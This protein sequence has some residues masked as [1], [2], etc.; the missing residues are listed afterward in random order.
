MESAARNDPPYVRI[1]AE[2]SASIRSGELQPGQRL[3]SIRQI[4][5]RWGVAVATATKVVATLREDGLVDSKVGS[6]TIVSVQPAQ[7][8]TGPPRR[9]TRPARTQ[10]DPVARA[11]SQ[12]PML[13][14]GIEIADAEGL[15][16]VSMR[17]IAADLGV[18]PMSLYRHVENKDELVAQMADEVFGE[19]ELPDPGPDGWRAKL[20]LISRAQWALCRQHIWLPRVISFTRPTLAPNMMAQTEWTLQALDG[21]GL[22]MTTRMQEALAVQS[23]VVAAAVS[24]ADE[25]DA[26]VESGITLT[27]WMAAQQQRVDALLASGGFPLLAQV[28]QETVADLDGLF[29]YSLARHLDGF[30]ALLEKSD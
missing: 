14:A 20:E 24:L 29:E 6:G 26:E 23:V 10:P 15:E 21:L 22:S 19:L 2:I 7:R 13:Q 18:A 16:A 27:R 1:V 30:A 5:D 25:I 17:R 12:R 8:R 3:P 28:H 11:L 9:S 4:A